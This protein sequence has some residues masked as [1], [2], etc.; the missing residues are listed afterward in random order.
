MGACSS[1]NC[2]AP[3]ATRLDQAALAAVRLARFK[4]YTENGVPQIV[5]TYVPIALELEN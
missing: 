2:R 1:S 4:P 5:W 3:R